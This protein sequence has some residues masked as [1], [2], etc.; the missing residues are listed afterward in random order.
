MAVT[1]PLKEGSV[2]TYQQKVALG[3]PDILASEMDADLDTIYAAWNGNVGTANLVDGSVTTAKLAPNLQTWQT[4]AG[5]PITPIDATKLVTLAPIAV[6]LQWGPTVKHYLADSGGTLQLQTNY[7]AAVIDTSKSQWALAMSA[8]GDSFTL[9]RSPAGAT[10]VFK[11]LLTLGGDGNMYLPTNGAN[12]PLIFG[13]RSEKGRLVSHPSASQVYLTCNGSLSAGGSWGQDTVG[14]QSWMLALDA[15]AS[16]V[17][18]AYRMA[19]GGA[20][21][22]PLQVDNVGNLT[23]SGATATKASG[24]TWANPSDPRL[25][26]DVMPY[27]RGLV[28]ILPLEPITY[29]LKAAP[30]GPLCYGFDAARVRDVFPECVSEMR[31]KLAPDDAEETDG[32][33]SF[34]MH[35]ILV[36]FVNA[37]K[38]LAARVA[39]LEAR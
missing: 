34:D 26:D 4:G 21:T 10:A 27:A 17:F 39:T 1:R 29:R 35:P 19:P 23:I 28:D 6:P 7:A 15:A 12:N 3:F 22:V 31:M 14:L 13:G 30:D 37:L 24:T 8:P 20:I 38:E 18:A 9:S 36:T 11:T 25:K 32:V 16:G 2:T 5:N 33:L